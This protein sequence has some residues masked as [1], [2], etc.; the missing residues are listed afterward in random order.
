MKLPNTCISSLGVCSKL[1]KNGKC[2]EPSPCSSVGDIAFLVQTS[3]VSSETEFNMEKNVLSEIAGQLNLGLN[4]TQ[5][6]LMYYS[7]RTGKILGYSVREQS[8]IKTVFLSKIQQIP[9]M[10]YLN[11]PISDVIAKSN[12]TF[13]SVKR[14]ENVPRVV[15][16]FNDHASQDSIAKIRDHAEDLKKQ[17]INIFVVGIGDK[18]DSNQL[19][20]IASSP[21]NIIKVKSH[22]FIYESMREIKDKICKVNARV[23]LDKEETII[24]GQKEYRYYKLSFPKGTEYLDIE[25]DQQIGSSFVYNSFS[26][27]NPTA[28]NSENSYRKFNRN[29]ILSSILVHDI[30]EDSNLLYFTIHGKEK[31]NEVKIT[32][33][34]IDL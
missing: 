21:K 25:I 4:K 17:D 24:T 26:Y 3:K 29:G 14:D 1:E 22:Q 12:A 28:E 15:V 20:T 18:V 30:P 13:F 6:G 8:S 2:H 27:E 16:I 31:Y 9:Y 23:Y 11:T 10:P 34:V 32:V 7:Q 5:L 19:M 33:R